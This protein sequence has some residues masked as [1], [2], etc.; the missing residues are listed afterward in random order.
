MLFANDKAIA[1]ATSCSLDVT[2]D[3]DATATKDTSGWDDTE[4]VGGNWSGSSDSVVGED[5]ASPVDLSY[6]E[7]MDLMLAKSEIT[8]VFGEL[9][10]TEKALPEAP[11]A[12]WTVADNGYTGTALITNVSISADNKANATISVTFSG[13]GAITKISEA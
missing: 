3:T 2:M 8:I 9:S 4:V 11:T 1:L 7:L 6:K 13:K 12:G 10:D 5:E